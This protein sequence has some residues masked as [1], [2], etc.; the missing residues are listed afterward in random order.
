MASEEGRGEQVLSCPCATFRRCYGD[1]MWA[2]PLRDCCEAVCPVGHL[3]V[4]KS[5]RDRKHVVFCGNLLNR[6]HVFHHVPPRC[7]AMQA[8]LGWEGKGTKP[9]QVLNW[10]LTVLV[11]TWHLGTRLCTDTGGI[12]SPAD[13]DG[14]AQSSGQQSWVQLAG[15]WTWLLDLGPQGAGGKAAGP[16]PVPVQRDGTETDR[17][18]ILL[19][20]FQAPIFSCW[21][22]GL[23]TGSSRMARS[24]PP[25]LDGLRDL[26]QELLLHKSNW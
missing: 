23:E 7:N 24:P 26:G 20:H 17:P 13:R 6:R 14:C 16:G 21:W 4:L 1:P 25:V 8:S 18:K 9:T 19:R 3:L 12:A 2:K 22:A 11:A 5:T 10:E 15:R